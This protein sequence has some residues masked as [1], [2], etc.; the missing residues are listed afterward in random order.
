[1]PTHNTN[2]SRS[3]PSVSIALNTVSGLKL[4]A[5]RY[6]LL[7]AFIQ[8]QKALL[9]RTYSDVERLRRLRDSVIDDPKQILSQLLDDKASLALLKPYMRSPSPFIVPSAICRP[10]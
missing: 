7:E 2:G 10:G 4:I 8:S 6:D 3:Q 1:M 9:A 5:T